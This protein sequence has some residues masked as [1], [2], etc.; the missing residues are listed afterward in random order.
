[1][2]KRKIWRKVRGCD[3]RSGLGRT[4]AS[5]PEQ[6]LLDSIKKKL[7]ISVEKHH[8]R[9][10]VVSGHEDCAGN[11]VENE[12]HK[13]D[14]LKSTEIIKKLVPNIKVIPVFVKRSDKEWVV[15]EF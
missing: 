10:I 11:P 14:V 15:E 4:L 8:S 13:K 1:M 9:N 6:S 3:N 12:K 5:S 2:G 7:L